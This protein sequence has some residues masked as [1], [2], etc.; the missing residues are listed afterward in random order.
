MTEDQ[1]RRANGIVFPVLMV[2]LGYIALSMGDSVL[3]GKGGVKVI[4]QGI[5]A[6]VAIIVSI[7]VFVRK[8]NT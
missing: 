5:V 2:I 8:R 7:V 3:A 1:Y 4:L 6:I